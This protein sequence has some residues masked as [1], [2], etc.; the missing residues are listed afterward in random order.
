MSE[1]MYK[2]KYL[3]YKIKYI[4]LFNK[5]NEFNIN[6][7]N[8]FLIQ[9]GNGWDCSMCTLENSDLDKRCK[10]CEAPKTN[11][12]T[13]SRCSFDNKE[14]DKRCELCMAPKAN[15]VFYIY[16]TGI[17]N[18]DD[19]KTVADKWNHNVCK[20]IIRQI[21]RR[22]TDI[23]IVHSDTLESMEGTPPFS[24]VDRVKITT[25]FNVLLSKS[26]TKHTRVKSSSFI[27]TPLNF[28]EL[29]SPHIV[30]DMAHLFEYPKTVGNVKIAEHYGIDKIGVGSNYNIHA[31]YLGFFGNDK[32]YN[33]KEEPFYFLT[34][35]S[36][37]DFI[38][39]NDDD[40]VTTY[41]DRLIL[42]NYDYKPVD[43][44]DFFYKFLHDAKMKIELFVNKQGKPITDE[45]NIQINTV[46]YNTMLPSL[47]K[48]IM[49]QKLSFSE[50][51]DNL[52][53]DSIQ[54]VRNY[55]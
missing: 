34:I 16:T 24:D 46:L 36:L 10:V 39:V 15:K 17:T 9:H 11:I 5:I 7:K 13:C 25:K 21:P 54:F 33:I 50:L 41:I 42:L 40:T 47:I 26:D 1:I 55:I 22:F 28:A 8:K 12:W 51:S 3:K 32:L 6:N 19:E 30:I 37:Y 44:S 31:V 20:N 4:N 18:W 27:S 52:I 49:S 14:S 2:N 23:H 29:N 45:I 48:N 35:A 43:P 53:Y 38:I